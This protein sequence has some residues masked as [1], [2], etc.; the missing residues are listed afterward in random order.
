MSLEPLAP[1]AVDTVCGYCGVGCG[2]TLDVADGAVT[3]A[4]GTKSHPA[5]R[6]RLCTKGATT[7]DMLRAPGRLTTAL[8]RERRD[9]DARPADVD[10]AIAETARRL[11]RIRDRHGPESIAVY[12]SG[13]MSLEAQYL[14][15]KLVKGFLGTNQIESNS[16]LCMASAGTG[17]KQSLGADGPPGSYDDIDHA[18]A[19]L[20]IGSNMADC[21][22][23]LFLRLLDRVAAGA[24]L[25]V[26]D[27][28][29]TATAT[30]AHIHLPVRPGTDLALL[31]GLLRLIV[32]EGGLDEEFVAAHTRGWDALAAML[33]DYPPERVAEL[34]GVD[35]DALR[36]TARILAGAENWMTL[37]TM[38]LNQSTHG[39]WNTNA[40]CN[41]HLATGTICRTG[42]GP[43][44]LTGQPNAMGGREMGYMGPGL[45]GQRSALDAGDR[46]DVEAAWGLEPGT[47]STDPG[48]GTVDMFEAMA[49][50]RIRA[51]WIICTNPVASVANRS[52]VVQALRRADFVVVQEA[53]TGTE[54]C[55]YADIVLPAALWTEAQGTMVNSER[56]ISLTS[57]A[58]APPGQARADWEL[59]SQIARGMGFRD[60]FSHADAAAVF[61]EIRGFHNPRTGWDL[62]GVDYARLREGPVQWPAAPGGPARNPIRYLSD[63]PAEPGPLFPTPDRRARFLAR[64]HM[65]PAELPDDDYPMVLTTG[66]LAHQWHTMTKT[67]RVAKL[68]RLDPGSFVQ[69]HPDDARPAGIGDGDMVEVRSRRGAVRVPARVDDAVSAGVCF[70]PMHW[71]DA[72]GEMLAVNAVTTDAVDPDSLQ[73]EFKACA[74]ALTRLSGPVPDNQE[75][76]MTTADPTAADPTATESS[77]LAVAL[78]VDAGEPVLTETERGYL[79]GLLRGLTANPPR[80]A[81]PTVPSQ[82]PLSEPA[83][84][85]VDGVLAGYFSRVPMTGPGSASVVDSPARRIRLV[86]A[87]QTGTAEEYAAQCAGAL[88][89]AGFDVIDASAER[90]GLGDLVGDVLFIV[91]TTGDGDAPDAAVGLWDALAGACAQDVDGLRFS[92]L[93]FGDSSYADFC[94]FA[95]KLDARLATLDAQRIA[96]AGYCEPDYDTAAA[97]WLAGVVAVLDSP[98]SPDDP[99]TAA[100]SRTCAESPP[101]PG[102]SRKNPFT[103]RVLENAVLTT[104]TAKEV[105]RIAFHLPPGSLEYT[106]G[107]ALGV[108]P[109]NSETLVDEWLARTG[110]DGAEAVTV[111]G[112]PV[113]LRQALTEDYEIAD[114]S[115]DLVA[116]VAERTGDSELR[117][118]LDDPAGFADWAWNRQ[119]VD[120]LATHPVSATAAQWLSVCRR[121]RPRLYSISSSPS[122]HPERVEATVSVVRFG[123]ESAPR[124]G[125]CSGFL[126]DRGPADLARIFI[127]PNK[128]FGPPVDPEAPAI[129]IGPGTGIAPFRAFLH[130]RAASGA[131]GD[132]WIF[133]GERHRATEFYYEDELAGFREAGVLTRLD[134]A[135]SRD[136]PE[137]VYVQH[138]MRERAPEIWEWLRRGAHV[139]VCGDAKHMAR[140]VDDTLKQIVAEHGRLAPSGAENYLRALSAEGRYVRDV[141]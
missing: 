80:D 51:A 90:T 43:F 70:V 136:Q 29:R 86:W 49:D 91:S 72:F 122:A 44:S 2:L 140:D 97:A 61:D 98:A 50:G 129:M 7:V 31:N 134:T 116:F 88:R 66:R 19:F 42:S 110:L 9:G 75:P 20:V 68:C 39:T 69:I 59:I 17:Y 5:N 56:S 32:D 83:R 62:R 115:R 141:Y 119:S 74:V 22:P 93:G 82:A 132:N 60:G 4:R 34:T 24:R 64:P 52:T 63:D 100:D 137:K 47:L 99:D 104:G 111:D 46:A 35:E 102:Y 40:V 95:R 124:R 3:G 37:W 26:V 21:H 120:L 101:A 6:G 107:D 18:D 71:S 138:L 92:V 58:V 33:D 113:P 130:E 123:D 108:W 48:G 106:A 121:L 67:G 117:A 89:D 126:A 127:T 81:V 73:P 103:A 133:F 139:Y 25:I 85:W 53:F 128:K 84:I 118:L 79:A 112:A 78:R 96:P 41:L 109:R 105:R 135:F 94:G 23:I 38:G 77:S 45:P 15:N 65:P 1:T 13:Q 30:K 55:E 57:P 11:T 27:P 54:T 125:V 8:I 12:V 10:D 76:P 131:A 16:R 114:C 28:R 36:E 14:A 87:S